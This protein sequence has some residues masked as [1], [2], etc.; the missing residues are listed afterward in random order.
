MQLAKSN[1]RV[2]FSLSGIRL[3]SDLLF[4]QWEDQ[5]E[6]DSRVISWNEFYYAGVSTDCTASGISESGA[7]LPPKGC[8]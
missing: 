8:L 1:H 5:N 6:A 7:A 3:I 2:Y 4:S